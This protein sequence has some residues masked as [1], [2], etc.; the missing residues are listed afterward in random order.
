[1]ILP[2]SGRK[3][4]KVS[5]PRGV[6]RGIR[7]RHERTA[8]YLVSVE[9]SSGWQGLF[10]RRLTSQPYQPVERNTRLHRKSRHAIS[11]ASAHLSGGGTPLPRTAKH[12]HQ[13]RGCLLDT[14]LDAAPGLRPRKQTDREKAGSDAAGFHY[15]PRQHPRPHAA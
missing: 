10:Y 6:V 7:R 9:R 4:P 14:A 11:S 12:A 1:P 3:T 15:R 2:P 8:A 5:I 13:L